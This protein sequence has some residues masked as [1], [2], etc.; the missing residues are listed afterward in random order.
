MTKTHVAQAFALDKDQGKPFWFTDS[1]FTVK[2]SGAETGNQLTVIEAMFPAGQITPLHVHHAEDEAWYVLEGEV[3]F[4]AAGESLKATTGSFVFGPKDVAH[5]FRVGDAGAKMLVFT[6]PS[7]FEKF[8]EEFGEPARELTLPMP[9]P[10]NIP[11]LLSLAPK[12]HFE[13]IPPD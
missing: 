1:L 3:M 10:I 2:L 8:V 9:Q 5:G 13:V 6:W 7:D 4:Q 12:Y 11:R